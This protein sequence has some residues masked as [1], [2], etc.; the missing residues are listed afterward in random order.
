MRIAAILT[1]LLLLLTGRDA[2]ARAAVSKSDGYYNFHQEQRYLN[3]TSDVTHINDVLK[4]VTK[5]VETECFVFDDVEDDDTNDLF[6][7]KVKLPAS[8]YEAPCYRSIVNY[9]YRCSK[10]PPSVLW[11]NADICILQSVL[12]I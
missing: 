11:T 2:Y 12:R 10:A 4:D 8:G 6:A 5:A 1:Y 3:A 7:K 9:L